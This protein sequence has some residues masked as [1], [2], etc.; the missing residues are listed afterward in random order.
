MKALRI[1]L[2]TSSLF[3]SLTAQLFAQCEFLAPGVELISVT[4]SGPNCTV[5]INLKF[6]IDRNHGNKYT[7]I[8]LWKE[9]EHP[10]INYS[11]FGPNAAAL[12][13]VL[14]TVAIEWSGSDVASLLTSYSP[15]PSIAPLTSGVGLSQTNVG[16]LYT[17]TLNNLSFAIPGACSAIPTLRGDVWGTQADSQTPTVH[18]ANTEI[19]LSID[20][21][22]VGG[23][24]NCQSPSGPRT[25]DLDV[26]TTNTVPMD[27]VYRL[28]LD[29]GV[30]VGGQPIFT[31]NDDLIYTS[32]TWPLSSG[33]P[34]DING[35]AYAHG[36]G[37]DQRSVWVEVTGT[38]LSN[39]IFE[40]LVNNCE[41]ILPVKLAKFKGDLLDNSVALS[42]VTTEEA[43]SS[44]F[45]IERSVDMKEFVS[46]GELLATGNSSST[47]NYQFVDAAPH[48]G[49]NYYR[50]KQLDHDGSFEY[51]RTISVANNKE[52][53][54][55]ELLGN[56]VENGEIRFLLK[57]ADISLIS[58][59]NQMGQSVKYTFVKEGN[60]YIVKVKNLMSK[61]LY[62]MFLKNGQTYLTK[63]ILFL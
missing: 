34:I 60:T 12:G 6:T 56:P 2:I 30:L 31:A 55:F 3:F 35:A 46:I 28:Y 58:L 7:Y 63:K 23:A 25:Y 1:Y 48:Q 18:C 38:G 11:A 4:T 43:G 14:A 37:E 54:V 20:D 26:T 10:T 57:N 47:Q 45:G 19:Y 21:P 40:R 8:H 51:S 16:D 59:T 15:D 5:N 49:N 53:L 62:L 36:V 52:S 29:D 61:G 39:T 32:A 41:A 22:V 9:L 17:V 44:K 42:W 13:P 33:N 27:V 24:I 50:L